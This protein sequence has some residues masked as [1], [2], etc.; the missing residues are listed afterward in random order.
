VGCDLHSKVRREVFW[1][2][3]RFWAVFSLLPLLLWLVPGDRGPAEGPVALA[4]GLVFW[5]A[6]LGAATYMTGGTMLQTILALHRAGRRTR[7]R[8]LTRLP[9]LSVFVC[10]VRVAVPALGYG[11]VRLTCYGLPSR[12]RR[13][14]RGDTVSVMLHAR[15]RRKAPGFWR[16]STEPALPHAKLGHACLA[17][18]ELA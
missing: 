1:A 16:V 14:R 6:F 18:E 2:G 11:S 17:V 10:Q 12:I 9:V 13:L 3:V 5:A 7:G 8:V 4:L 15:G